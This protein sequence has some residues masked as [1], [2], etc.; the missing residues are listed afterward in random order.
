MAY[1]YFC[2]CY[3]IVIVLIINSV[4]T[5]ILFLT[6]SDHCMMFVTSFVVLVTYTIIVYAIHSDVTGAIEYKILLFDS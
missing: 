3:I 1:V 2:S 5:I 4:M 6:R